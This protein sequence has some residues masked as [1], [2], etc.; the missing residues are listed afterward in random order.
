MD[1][2]SET[3]QVQ[4]APLPACISGKHC[5]S[6]DTHKRV[7]YS[8]WA[9]HTPIQHAPCQSNHQLCNAGKQMMLQ[10]VAH[11][12]CHQQLQRMCGSKRCHMHVCGAI[13][14]RSNMLPARQIAI[15]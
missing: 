7:L 14:Y 13:S 4:A 6:F 9:K 10:Q 11:P 2:L 12:A 3:V 5:R 15:L 8:S 1:T